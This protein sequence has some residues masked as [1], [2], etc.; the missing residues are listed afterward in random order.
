MKNVIHIVGAR[1]NFIKAAPVI[2]K[3]ISLNPFDINN[4]ILHTGQH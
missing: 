4:M 2:K 3:M 1:P